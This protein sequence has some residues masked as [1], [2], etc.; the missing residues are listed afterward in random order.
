M[1]LMLPVGTGLVGSSIILIAHVFRWW[2]FFL[3]LLEWRVEEW[4]GDYGV[5]L[6]SLAVTIALTALRG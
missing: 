6:C 2:F 1:V 4:V 3:A 5:T